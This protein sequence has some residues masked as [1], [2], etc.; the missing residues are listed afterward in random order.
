MAKT[1]YQSIDQ[2]IAEFPADVQ[3][4]LEAVRRIIYAA[5][6]EAEEVISYQI[7]CFK[8]NGPV[9][10]FSAYTS[11]IGIAAPPPTIEVFKDELKAYKT[12]K[13]VFQIPFDQPLPKELIARM[14][15]WRASENAKKNE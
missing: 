12:S 14:A 10:Y 6:P 9:L 7:P 1:D 5:V 15:Q 3:E 11:H 4:K 2:Y 13:S 8:Q